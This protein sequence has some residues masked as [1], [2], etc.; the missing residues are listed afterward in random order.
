MTDIR[1]SLL[2][3]KGRLSHINEEFYGE[4]PPNKVKAKKQATNSAR[5]KDGDVPTMVSS[6]LREVMVCYLEIP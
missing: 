6:D 4:P 3:V 1:A 5:Y 2:N